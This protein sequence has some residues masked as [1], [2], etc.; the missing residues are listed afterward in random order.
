MS[1]LESTIKRIVPDSKVESKGKD[2]VVKSKD[3]ITTKKLVEQHFTKNNIPFKSIMKKSKSSSLEVLEMPNIGDIIFKPIIQKGAG[4]LGFEKE[5][6]T[7]LKNYFNG[8]EATTEFRHPDA[9]KEIKS[10]LNL[11]L[12]EMWSV[13]PEGSK[14]QKR[15]ISFNGS[16]LDI[17]NS[18]GETLTDLTLKNKANKTVYLSLKMSRTY[19]TVSA[20]IGK[21]FADKRTQVQINEYFGFNGMMMGGFGQEF[22]CN[23]TEN[24][25]WAKVKGHLEELLDDAVGHNVV[26]VHK[27]QQNDVKV[28]IIGNKN[29]VT[30]S[31]LNESNYV[32]P[33]PGV[34]KYANIKAVAS[35]NG[36]RYTVNFQFRGTAASDVGPKYIR[37]LLE[38]M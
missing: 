33:E 29:D 19:Y 30:I 16:K 31:T 27:K 37:V 13:I 1:M 14:N 24:P 35:I 22:L 4:G 6:E 9:I 2:I 11:D 3:R 17:L 12:T 34:R 7:D 5:L 25:N 18:S 38:R 26:L 23:T 21:Y 15:T 36:S 28:A 10:V 20:S 8:A 32:Y